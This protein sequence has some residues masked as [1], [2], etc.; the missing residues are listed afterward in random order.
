MAG[1]LEIP[2]QK[3][4]SQCRRYLLFMLKPGQGLWADFNARHVGVGVKDVEELIGV[5]SQ[6]EGLVLF[7]H[8]E[9]FVNNLLSLVERC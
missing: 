9:P 5:D 1:A 8:S 4:C 2:L 6:N 7:S 3:G